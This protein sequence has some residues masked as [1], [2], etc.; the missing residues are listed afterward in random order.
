MR[1]NSIVI[2]IICI[3]LNF[4]STSKINNKSIYTKWLNLN[5]IKYYI[6]L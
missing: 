6:F 3:L 1:K 4:L 2:D 5:Y